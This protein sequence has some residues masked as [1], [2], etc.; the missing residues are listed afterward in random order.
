LFVK[1]DKSKMTSNIAVGAAAAVNAV[2]VIVVAI[3]L[4]FC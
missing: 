3:G 2:V 4:S 1:N